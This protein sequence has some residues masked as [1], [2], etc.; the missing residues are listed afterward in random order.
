MEAFGTKRIKTGGRLF[1]AVTL[2]VV[3]AVVLKDF[4]DCLRKHFS[5]SYKWTLIMPNSQYHTNAAYACKMLYSLRDF[6]V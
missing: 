5:S 4:R 6:V 2:D 1:E 3:A